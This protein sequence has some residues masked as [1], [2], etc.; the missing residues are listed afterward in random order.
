MAYFFT[1][2]LPT[3]SLEVKL[4]AFT[5]AVSKREGQNL[6]LKD[7]NIQQMY[8]PWMIDVSKIFSLF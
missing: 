4:Q 8:G 6:L 2:S 7:C 1:L 5:W 3:S